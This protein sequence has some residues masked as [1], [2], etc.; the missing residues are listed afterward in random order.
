MNSNLRNLLAQPPEVSV[1]STSKQACKCIMEIFEDFEQSLDSS[2][3]TGM[4][5]TS[6]GSS[7]Q[8][9]VTGLRALPC[10]LIQIEGLCSG[11]PVSLV[12][13]V[14]QLSFLL[15]PVQK[16]QPDEPRRKIGFH[17]E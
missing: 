15:I 7:I 17:M 16:A 10:N 12:Q 11:Q 8:I 6:F 5:L 14:S 3:E 2:E 9:V 4:K 1:A 13:N